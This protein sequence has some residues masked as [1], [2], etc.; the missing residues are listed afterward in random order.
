MSHVFYCSPTN[1]TF[2][3]SCCETAI[4]DHQQKCPRCRNDVYPF[5]EG[6]SDMAREEAAG[7]YYN[8]NTRMARSSQAGQNAW[9]R[10]ARP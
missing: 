3:T 1:S 8:H 5:Y 7:G 9:Y 10:K 6:M 2:F 4:C